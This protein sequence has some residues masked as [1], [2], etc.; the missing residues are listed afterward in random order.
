MSRRRPERR[1]HRPARDPEEGG[2][3]PRY[4]RAY[5][6]VTWVNM[7]VLSFLL[8]AFLLVL[9]FRYVG[10]GEIYSATLLGLAFV[11]TI[12]IVPGMVV[13]AVLGARTY[14]VERRLGLR[15]GA[16]IGAV[17]GLA[18]YLFFSLVEPL[19]LLA[20]PHVV[21]L[22][23][24]LYVLFAAGRS[25]ERRQLVVILAAALSV[26]SAAGTFLLYFDPL[27]L[28]GALVATAASAAGGFVGGFGYARAGGEEM[29]PDRIPRSSPK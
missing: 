24:L 23:L 6:C 17:A 20:A 12:L 29:L 11:G 3:Q 28:L 4:R 7:A 16:G 21:S 9:P 2:I 13:G 27:A 22:G 8:V 25:L 14:R 1:E 19:P 18:G 15:A 10:E 5:G 26:I